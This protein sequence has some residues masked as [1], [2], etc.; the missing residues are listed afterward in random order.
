MI[1]YIL[2]VDTPF[3][4]TATANG[5]VSINDVPPGDYSLRIW[6]SRLPVGSAAQKQTLKVAD[7]DAPIKVTLKGLGSQ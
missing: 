5:L 7:T 2:V 4:G 3:Y 6:H 1:A